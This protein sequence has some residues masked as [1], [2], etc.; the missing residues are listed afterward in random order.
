M[1]AIT[2]LPKRSLTKVILAAVGAVIGAGLGFLVGRVLKAAQVD[3]TQLGW[4]D[5]AA[6]LIAAC[7]LA[8]GMLILAMSFNRRAAGRMVDP[9]SPKPA[10]SA[11]ASFYRQQG[12]VSAL[13]GL[14]MAA[15][16]AVTVLNKG[17]PP[18]PIAIIAMLGVV[19][20]FLVQTMVNLTLWRRS[21][22]LFRRVISETGASCFWIFQ[23]LLFLWAVAEK[24]DLAPTLSSWDI[25]TLLMGLYLV[26]STVT[27]MRRGLS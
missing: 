19:A 27:S 15:P 16:V 11:Q 3:A 5:A 7:L 4:S 24:L 8:M 2:D 12:L 6:G 9:H 10:T 25:M 18:V 22:E 13:A 14:M 23:G 20:A 26:A 1:N 21:D 17:A